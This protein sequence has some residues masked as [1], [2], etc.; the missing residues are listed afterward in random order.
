MYELVYL[1]QMGGEIKNTAVLC[2]DDQRDAQFL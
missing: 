1:V 2:V